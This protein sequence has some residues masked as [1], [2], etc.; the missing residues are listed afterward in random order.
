MA[1]GISTNPQKAYPSAESRHMAYLFVK[2][3]TSVQPVRVMTR[4]K[5][6]QKKEILQWRNGYYPDY[7]CRPIEIVS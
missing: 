3:D 4:T 6:K 7:P 2:M 1:K 5:K